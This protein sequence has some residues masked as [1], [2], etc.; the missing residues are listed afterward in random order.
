MPLYN[1]NK[2]SGMCFGSFVLHVNY[3]LSIKEKPT[4]KMCCDRNVGESELC[5]C[6]ILLIFLQ[7]FEPADSFFMED[8]K[9]I[10]K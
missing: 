10:K 2:K 4:A 7:I 1:T 3:N 6:K 8:K 9:K 5:L